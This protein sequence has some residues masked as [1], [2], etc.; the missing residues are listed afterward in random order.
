MGALKSPAYMRYMR[1]LFLIAT[2]RTDYDTL[3]DLYSCTRIRTPIRRRLALTRLRNVP[4][5]AR[6]N[7][8]FFSELPK[9]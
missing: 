7:S 8:E 1:I 5:Q 3:R 2:S 6:D 4:P 9:L